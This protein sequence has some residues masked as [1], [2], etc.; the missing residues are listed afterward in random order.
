MNQTATL[1]EEELDLLR[2]RD[3][4]LAP[5]VHTFPFYNRLIWNFTRDITG[6][7]VAYSLNYNIYDANNDGVI[8]ELDA[9]ILFP[10]AHGDA[11]GHYLM[12][13][14]VYYRLLRNNYFEWMPR[15]E[16]VL[17]GG[18]PVAVDYY[19]ER[20]FAKVSAQKAQTG[21]EIV[22]L[23]YR[24][25]YVEN[26]NGQWQGYV[27]SST[28]RMWGF[29]EWSSRAGQGAYFD[30]VVGNALLPPI[31]PNPQ[32]AGIQKID[33]TTV[34]DLNDIAGAFATIQTKTDEADTGLNPLGLSRNVVP[35]DLDPNMLAYPGGRPLTHFDQIYQRAGKA[36]QNAVTV[37]DH[38]KNS[39]QNLR[40]QNDSI[41]DF[42]VNV[43]EKETDFEN[44]LIEIYGYPYDNDIGPLGSYASGYTGPDLYHWMYV[45]PLNS[46]DQNRFTTGAYVD[47]AVK[48]STVTDNG[49]LVDTTATI[50]YTLSNDGLM[51]V[52]PAAWTGSRRAQGEL[53]LA[54]SDSRQLRQR[55]EQAALEYQQ[56]VL[57]I[58][59]KANTIV[60][61]ID[62][63]TASTNKISEYLA[64][65]KNLN[66]GI[67]VCKVALKVIDLAKTQVA[68]EAAK[69]LNGVPGVMGVVGGLANGVVMSPKALAA[70]PICTIE[71]FIYFL[72][73]AEEALYNYTMSMLESQKFYAG[74]ELQIDLSE[75]EHDFP[76]HESVN[77]LKVLV[78]SEGIKRVEL[79]RIEEQ[80][81]QS[82]GKV[83]KL[84]AEGQRELD[85]RT[86]FRQRTAA[87]TQSYRYKDMAFR[88]FRDDALQKY[89]AQFDLAAR[90]A[91]L[92]AKAYDFETALEPDDPRGSGLQYLT[93]IVRARAIGLVHN[94]QPVTGSG[95][96]DPG[97]ADVLAKMWLNWDLVLRSQLGLNNPTTE[98]NQFSLRSELFRCVPNEGFT[99]PAANLAN[100]TSLVWRS[101]LQGLVVSN[102]LALP[103]FQ[104][105]C[106][107]P[108]PHNATEPG[109]VLPFST[110]IEFGRNLFG[111]PLGGADSAYDSS[112]YATKIAA[113][114][115]VFGNY[116][117]LGLASDPRVYLLP[118]GSDVL[119]CPGTDGTMRQWRI[120]DQAL[121]VPFPVSAADMTDPGWIPINDTLTTDFGDLRRFPS[122]RAY[123]DPGAYDAQ[124]LYSTSRLFGRSAW[125][126]EWILIIPAGTL[127]ADRDLAIARF[128]DGVTD[129]KLLLDTFSYSGT[130]R[131]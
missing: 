84:L 2:G 115:I 112:Q 42:Q 28:N 4:K 52:K 10:Q 32:H 9:R 33:R 81:G 90:Y 57:E 22:N 24:Q 72:L 19:D 67:G 119:R 54:Y 124:Y 60:A 117:T 78:K 21:A 68:K 118:V 80:I 14:K 7:E 114:G 20:K 55:F 77:E 74:V 48:Q 83:Q 109:I 18:V 65:I 94:G 43:Q 41:Q 110:T 100:E 93:D 103:E 70:M 34:S 45:E 30:W 127:H 17:V 102:F 64:E 25:H 23:T 1:L 59:M 46:S 82:M 75:L 39:T 101:T 51:M 111:W 76:I 130:K 92:A 3:N 38:A 131:R 89:R 11:W 61:Q 98:K 56:I 128:V 58:E 85:R 6:G 106:I 27:D 122:F 99:G 66:F 107:P 71:N 40:R 5:S 125:N 62:L 44:R 13:N 97:L 113:M 36:L 50:R 29:A 96:G 129:I 126:T 53:Q 15:I 12:A 73:C 104:R 116:N 63:K 86:V 47:V 95:S 120:F 8:D 31:D 37:F 88:I 49:G 26:V 105:Y 123:H 35:F 79:F 69:A 121:P 91:Y 16:S 87:Q 108:Q